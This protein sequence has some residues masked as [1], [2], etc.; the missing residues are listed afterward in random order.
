MTRIIITF[1][2]LSF[3]LVSFAGITISDL[4]DPS[5]SDIMSF[6]NIIGTVLSIGCGIY[7]TVGALRFFTGG[8]QNDK[9]YLLA[10]LV[11]LII[12]IVIINI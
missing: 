7:L 10:G 4:A 3:H 2:I 8:C 12:G 9:M 1:C 11:G 6:K 5:N